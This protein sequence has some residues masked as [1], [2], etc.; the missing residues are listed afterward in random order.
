MGEL[1]TFVLSGAW[2]WIAPV[3]VSVGLA[4][5]LFFCHL[6][7]NTMESNWKAEVA[8]HQL[9]IANVKAGTEKAKADA[10]EHARTVEEAN[11]VIEVQKQ[12]D[13]VKQLAA[14][15]ADA[16]AYILRLQTAANR[17]S[18]NATGLPQASGTS[19]GASGASPSPELDDAESCAENTVKA[20]GWLDW[21]HAISTP[22]KTSPAP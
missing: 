4:V 6:H 22:T 8:A 18:A 3:L 9:D 10:L 19:S 13:L 2:K 14:A 20:E 11:H 15:R 7:G 17:G 5:A 12:A 16:N 1:I 21:Y